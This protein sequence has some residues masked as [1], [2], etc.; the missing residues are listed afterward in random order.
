M[1][2]SGLIDIP[3]LFFIVIYLSM[4]A[5]REK[6]PEFYQMMSSC[7]AIFL[8]ATSLLKMFVQVMIN[9]KICDLYLAKLDWKYQARIEATLAVDV[10][11]D[12]GDFYEDRTPNQLRCY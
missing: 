12:N 8:G 4:F 11:P 5:F 6:W 2:H 9:V 10:S 7:L 3:A 1:C